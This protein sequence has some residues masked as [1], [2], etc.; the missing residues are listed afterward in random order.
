MR[1]KFVLFLLRGSVIMPLQVMAQPG[2]NPPHD[3]NY[4]VEFKRQDQG[5]FLINHCEK[6][7]IS[8]WCLLSKASSSGHCSYQT[9][10]VEASTAIR[11][12]PFTNARFIIRQSCYAPYRPIESD[13][14]DAGS[15]RRP[16]ICE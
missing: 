15:G 3:A 13:H 7:T 5:I 1:Y 11:I 9:S 16:L 2:I 10:V 8:R 12:S 6:P 14:I 4:C